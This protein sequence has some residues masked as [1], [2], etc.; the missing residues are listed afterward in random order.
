MWD[1]LLAGYLDENLRANAICVK[2]DAGENV[3]LYTRKDYRDANQRLLN[4]IA[5]YDELFADEYLGQISHY[6]YY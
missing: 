3:K 2:L 5:R 6:I 4:I 1:L